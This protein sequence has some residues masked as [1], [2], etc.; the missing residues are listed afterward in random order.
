M[1]EEDQ[2]CNLEKASNYLESIY[3]CSDVF[4]SERSLL[5]KVIDGSA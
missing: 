1:T 3:R 5:F 4:G 2:V